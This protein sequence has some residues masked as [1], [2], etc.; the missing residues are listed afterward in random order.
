MWFLSEKEQEK[1]ASEIEYYTKGL[2]KIE[3]IL[4]DE[5]GR[6]QNHMEGRIKQQDDEFLARV[7]PMRRK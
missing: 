1:I 5:M 2:G 4:N 7:T 6:L 3:S